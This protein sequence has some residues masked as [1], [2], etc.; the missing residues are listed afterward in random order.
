MSLSTI[1]RTTARRSLVGTVLAAALLVPAATACSSSADAHD[2][3]APATTTPPAATAPGTP[4]AP[5]ASPTTPAAPTTSAKSGAPAPATAPSKGGVT[6]PAA[7]PKGTAAGHSPTLVDGSTAEIR[8]L[9]NQNYSAKIVNSGQVL[10]TLETK[11]ED[12]GLNA[13]GMF[14]VLSLD[15]TIH[16]WMGGSHSGPGTVKLAGGWTA[17]V[18]KTGELHYRAEILG[19][20]NEV[21]GTLDADQ[22]DSGAA[23][24]GVYI[25]LSAGGEISAHA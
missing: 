1:R 5:P 25:V 8:D 16:S 7:P 12:A 9:G 3:A 21:Y 4:A 20:N 6:T 22:H 18:T 17:K 23:A 15:G 13:N 11:N 24:N 10:A 19:M 2:T 14:V